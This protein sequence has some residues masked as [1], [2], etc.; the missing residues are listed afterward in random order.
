LQ[1]G[2]EVLEKRGDCEI[3]DPNDGLIRVKN[4]PGK[5]VLIAKTGLNCR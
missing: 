2:D 1:R 3:V 5:W 4:E